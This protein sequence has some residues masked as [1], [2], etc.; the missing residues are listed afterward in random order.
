VER[1]STQR[2]F[3]GPELSDCFLALKGPHNRAQ[4]KASAAAPSH[5]A[6]S[7]LG[8]FLAPFHGAFHIV[9]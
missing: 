3:L 4:G 6:P 2:A 5:D 7:L 1:G 9:V 8:H